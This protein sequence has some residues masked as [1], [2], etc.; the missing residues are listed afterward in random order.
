M[1]ILT[2]TSL[3]VGVWLLGAAWKPLLVNAT[4]LIRRL[5]PVVESF[6]WSPLEP[7]IRTLGVHLAACK[8]GIETPGYRAGW[9][10][11]MLIDAVV[12]STVPVDVRQV[13]EMCGAACD[14]TR[15]DGR[16]R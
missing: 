5:T 1:A 16:Q 14:A 11:F 12:Y 15:Y 7:L 9:E 6:L 3:A 10:D 13:V 4:I 2:W 8:L